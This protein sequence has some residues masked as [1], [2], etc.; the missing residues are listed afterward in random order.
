VRHARSRTR[1]QAARS[2]APV[3]ILAGP[4]QAVGLARDIHRRSRQP[5]RRSSSSIPQQFRDAVPAS[6]S[7]IAPAP[8]SARRDGR[9]VEAP[10]AAL[11]LDHLGDPPLAAQP[12]LSGCWPSAS[13]AAR[14]RRA[15][16][17]PALNVAS[18]RGSKELR[19]GL[20]S[21]LYFRLAVLAWARRRAAVLVHE[22]LADLGRFGQARAR[23]SAAAWTWFEDYSG[24]ACAGCAT[25][26]AAR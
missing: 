11:V 13:I 19:R 22:T 17:R 8:S 18:R 21:G 5:Q 2:D 1:R 16:R 25:F 23:V 20:P 3:L 14:R 4:A 26:S 10:K 15:R 12:K 6:S 24:R 9:R 7:A